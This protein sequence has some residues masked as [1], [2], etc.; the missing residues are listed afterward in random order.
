MLTSFTLSFGNFFGSS[1][2]SPICT[3][4]VHVRC[5]QNDYNYYTKL[6]VILYFLLNTTSLFVAQP[7]KQFGLYLSPVDFE[8][9]CPDEIIKFSPLSMSLTLC[10]T[11][12]PLRAPDEYCWTLTLFLR[13]YLQDTKMNLDKKC[14][15]TQIKTY[16]MNNTMASGNEWETVRIIPVKKCQY[17]SPYYLLFNHLR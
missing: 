8:H 17:Q 4:V 14:L 2:Y 10:D 3:M 12:T 7:Q 16:Y 9:R 11:D 5:V 1:P 6:L 15:I 13:E